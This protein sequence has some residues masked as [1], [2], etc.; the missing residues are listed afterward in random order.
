MVA[1]SIQLLHL[2]KKIIGMVL[3]S[4][5]VANGF[6]EYQDDESCLIFASGIS[7]S[8]NTD[9]DAFGREA[10]LLRKSIQQN[11]D[12]L[13]VYFGTCSV[14]DPSLRASPYVNH[15]LAMEAILKKNHTDFL[16]FRISNL[17]GKTNNP[18][19]V[20]NF[21]ANHILSG[22]FFSLWKN[23]SRNIIDLGDAVT[24]CDYLIKKKIFRNEV[25][26]IANPVNYPVL[27][28][29]GVMEE[30][31]GKKGNYEL[32]EKGYNLEIDTS[33]I[34]PF[35]TELKIPFDEEYLIRTLT[36]YYALA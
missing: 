7:N 27:Q 30:M 9:T 2:P 20:L 6:R 25:V 18:H 23:A 33:P 4:G 1:Y 19:T 28:I 5:L 32:I 29:I 3:G 10:N 26:N 8:A 22:D 35:L 12:K 31:L 13:I 15:K 21:F 36:K 16:I 14:Y 34:Q 11:P 24:L 17:A